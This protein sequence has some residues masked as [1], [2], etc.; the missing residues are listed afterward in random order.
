MSEVTKLMH[1]HRIL[2]R[3]LGARDYE[4]SEAEVESALKLSTAW[5]FEVVRLTAIARLEALSLDPPRVL[6]LAHL[7]DVEHWIAPQIECL[8]LR[9]RSLTLDEAKHIGLETTIEICA[10][11]DKFSQLSLDIV[12]EHISAA[13]MA[14][15]RLGISEN[16]KKQREKIEDFAESEV[17]D[18]LMDIVGIPD[19]LDNGRQ[20]TRSISP[21]PPASAESEPERKPEQDIPLPSSMATSTKTISPTPSAA[22]DPAAAASSVMPSVACSKESDTSAKEKGRGSFG[23]SGADAGEEK[24]QD[25]SEPFLPPHP[26]QGRIAAVFRD[27]AEQGNNTP[28]ELEPP[29]A[30]EAAPET[31]EPEPEPP[32][33]KPEPKP[34]TKTA[35]VAMSKVGKKDKKKSKAAQKAEAETRKREGVKRRRE[36]KAAL[37]KARAE[38]EAEKKRQEE[39]KAL[40]AEQRRL[41]EE[42]RQLL[43]EQERAEAER[44][45][46][47]K[48]AAVEAAEQRRLADA[49]A[50]EAK[51]ARLKAE[52]EERAKAKAAEEVAVAAKLASSAAEGQ[53]PLGRAVGDGEGE[54]FTKL[55][56]EV[57]RCEE[58]A[59][60]A[61][62][63]VDKVKVAAAKIPQPKGKKGRKKPAPTPQAKAAE[64]FID[65]A[66]N[67]KERLGKA[68][69]ILQGYAFRKEP[70]LA[71]SRGPSSLDDGRCPCRL[72]QVA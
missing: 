53:G 9:P 65:E 72:C 36:E 39:G 66:V 61:Q 14:Q 71:S 27:A 19:G 46:K 64:P 11:R 49:V 12:K 63:E 37:A 17:E 6:Q 62:G 55:K 59:E 31:K 1:L 58:D 41:E 51:E 20:K 7:Y 33:A 38:A 24:P 18:K 28:P 29:G 15:V 68:E 45:R 70:A 50:K 56:A 3:A 5:N 54:K 13:D 47:G 48:E 32:A 30:T 16:I 35:S 23:A 26:D 57:R 25:A 52:E 4:L 69:K 42:E 67:K 34:I 44:L 43:A 10:H 21:A 60:K 8:A 2:H 40:A 22:L